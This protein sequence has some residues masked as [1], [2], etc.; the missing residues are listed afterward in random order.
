MASL[1]VNDTVTSKDVTA[2]QIS[3]EVAVNP[4]K[5]SDNTENVSLHKKRYLHWADEKYVKGVNN[6]TALSKTKGEIFL[7]ILED[8]VTGTAKQRS[9]IKSRNFKLMEVDGKQVLGQL[10]S[11]K[12][13]KGETLKII[14]HVTKQVAFIEDF[15]DILYGI[16]NVILCHLGENKTQYQVNLRYACFPEAAIDQYCKL[17]PVCSLKVTQATQARIT[18]IASY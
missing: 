4:E 11:S 13:K 5:P 2:V 7:A 1:I 14:T 3:T 10:I 6:S 16:H 8:K 9:K 18:P 15:Y 12:P 17:C